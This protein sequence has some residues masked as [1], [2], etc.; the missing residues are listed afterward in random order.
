MNDLTH[1]LIRPHI[2]EKATI[3][4][5]SSVYVFEIDARTTKAI[6]KKAFVEKYKITPLKIR[7]VTIPAKQVFVRG[8]RG[9][10]ASYKKAYIYLKKGTKL[11]NL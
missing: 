2:T 6:V 5:E 7:T 1:I 8:K 9:T 4:A 11:E 10:K 3:S